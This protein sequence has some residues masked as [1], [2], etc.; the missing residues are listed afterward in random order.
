MRC[1]LTYLRK[2]I[3]SNFSRLPF[4]HKISYALTYRCNLRC[5]MCNIWKKIPEKELTLDEIT[6]FFNNSNRFSW[7]GLTGG[8][9]FLRDDI[10]AIVKIVMD[11]CREL[12]AVHFATNGTLT[13]KI[14]STTE[15][16]LRHKPRKTKLLF[17]LSIDGPKILHDEIRGQQGTWERCI[18]T[19]KA[20]KNMHIPSLCVRIGFTLS[21]RNTEAF[22]ETFQS[23]K[24]VYPSL[25]FDD[26]SVNVFQKSPFYY[27]NHQMP[28]IDYT[29]I[30]KSIEK[31]L[32]MD[33]D[34]FTLNNFLRRKYL[35]L[36]KWFIRH[37]KCPLRCQA[38]SS[39][40]LIDPQGD[41]YPCGAYNAKVANICETGYDLKKIWS[42]SHVKKLSREC[43]KSVCPSCWSPCD[44]Y[45]AIAGSLFNPRLWRI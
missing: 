29:Q 45:S 1:E 39:T 23:L 14:T 42:L 37:K 16:I 43:S 28:D 3:H 35:R 32:A 34:S 33:I 30:L 5:A 40:C 7:V 22:S 8:E 17:T 18:R 6:A 11:S 26:L 10:T 2:L 19:F 24:E 27:S 21:H 36:Y 41:I 31:I 44:A 15:D 12:S 25:R 9:P 38:L 4:P 13:D 20:L